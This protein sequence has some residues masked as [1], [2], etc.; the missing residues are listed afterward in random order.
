MAIEC[1]AQRLLDP[2]RGAML[3]I[4]YE[5]AEAVT[6][7][8]VRWD[9]YVANDQL[10]EGVQAQGEVQVSDIRYGSWT[11][12]QGL[13]RG[14]LYP[15]ED[16]RRL[17]AMGAT[18]YEHLVQVQEQI[19][20]PFADQLRAVADGPRE[21]AARPAA[22]RRASARHG[23]GQCSAVAGRHRGTG[24]IQQPGGRRDHCAPGAARHPPRTTS[25]AT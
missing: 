12:D 17:E 15:S 10:R 19:P 20:F 8:G 11:A 16:F 7:D 1:Y 25:R 21:A 2:Y 18:V 23:D 5:A 24:A 6:L 3:T 14:P 13:K 22:E 9:I 4:R